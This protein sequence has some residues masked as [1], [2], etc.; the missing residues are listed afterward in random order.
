MVGNREKDWG[1]EKKFAEGQKMQR[2]DDLF[3][4]Y[5]ELAKKLQPKV[6]LAENVKGLI[7]GNA[8]SYVKKIKSGYE[9]AG[10]KVQLFLLNAASMGVPQKRERVFF[11]CQRQD[12]N[13]P[14]LELGFNEE[15]VPLS[16]IAD[17]SGCDITPHQ[18]M[19]WD[20]RIDSDKDQGAVRMRL[21]GKPTGFA[22]KYL[23]LNDVPNTLTSNCN[24]HY[25]HTKEPKAVSDTE[26]MQ[27]GSYPMDYDFANVK[28]IYLIG[29]SVPPVMTAQIANQIY[30]QWLNKI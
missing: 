30:L 7:S 4:D 25:I 14:K 26:I 9:D 28:P 27:I 19:I 2:L 18:K 6:V 15:P 11:I 1:K 10:Y 12:L 24:K 3:F 5:I 29:M 23:Y 16:E 17:Y 20:K 8:K 13:L 21:D 22:H